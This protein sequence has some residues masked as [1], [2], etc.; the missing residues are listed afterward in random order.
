M[1]LEKL[2][3]VCQELQGPLSR[4][5]VLE[6]LANS[7]LRSGVYVI[8]PHDW[9]WVYIGSTSSI[10]RRLAE[11]LYLLRH[12]KHD[13]YEMQTDFTDEVKLMYCYQLCDTRES[14]YALEQSIIDL[15]ANHPGLLNVATD[16]K[17]PWIRGEEYVH[18]LAGRSR[19]DE[20]KR[21]VSDTVKMQFANG[22]MAP[23]AGRK[24]SPETKRLISER[25]TGRVASEETKQKLSSQ[26]QLG[27]HSRA[28]PVVIDGAEYDC[29]K[30][31][32]LALNIP[33]P[34]VYHRVC[35]ANP[36]FSRWFFKSS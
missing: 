7:A 23:M 21:K 24:L 17:S 36:E 31:A 16:A 19:S 33:Y 22:R 3:E 28:K 5:A 26:R 20:F 8:M 9:A 4:N 14:A 29:V 27:K 30:S 18:P 12:Q 13:K 2:R 34:T 25:S 1:D 32:A 6:A 10:P 11:H 35:S 15:F